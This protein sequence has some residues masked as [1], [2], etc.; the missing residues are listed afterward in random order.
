MNEYFNLIFWLTA[1]IGA[2]LLLGAMFLRR[3]G[4]ADEVAGAVHG[5]GAVCLGGGFISII[6][7]YMG[8]FS[9]LAVLAVL[10]AY[11]ATRAQGGARVGL[12]ILAFGL[13]LFSIYQLPGDQSEWLATLAIIAV[14]LGLASALVGWFRPPK[15]YAD[16]Q[17]RD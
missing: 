3:V 6:C 4:G 16:T 7:L 10:C 8:G 12:G 11:L 14:V 17:T 13:A 2:V 5:I 1:V 9:F 15:L